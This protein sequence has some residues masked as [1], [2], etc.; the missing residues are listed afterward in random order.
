MAFAPKSILILSSL[1]LFIEL[2]MDLCLAEADVVNK[3]TLKLVQVIFRHGDR[4]PTN[5]YPNDPYYDEFNKLWPQGFA[6][7]TNVLFYST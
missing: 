4:A 6:Q 3:E 1:A 7:L 2:G 5:F